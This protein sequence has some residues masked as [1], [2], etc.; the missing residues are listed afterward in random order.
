MIWSLD[1]YFNFYIKIFVLVFIYVFVLVLSGPMACKILVPWLGTEPT[2]PALA[3]EK[4]KWSHSVVSDS[5][6]PH[7]L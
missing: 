6:R 4:W 2:S 3:S 1:M 5:F 7:G